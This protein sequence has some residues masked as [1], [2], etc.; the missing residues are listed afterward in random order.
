MNKKSIT[1]E[2]L[3]SR[4]SN[5]IDKA[6]DAT[7]GVEFSFELGENCSSDHLFT[8]VKGMNIYRIIQE[9]VNNALKHANASNISVVF[10]SGQG[11]ML[12]HITDNGRGFTRPDQLSSHGLLNMEK[13]AKEIEGDLHIDSSDQGTTVTLSF[14]G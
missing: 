8:S 7:S 9:A 5:F 1:I 4:I 12:V 11:Q 10:D 2:D 14:P 3:S 6:R 13:R